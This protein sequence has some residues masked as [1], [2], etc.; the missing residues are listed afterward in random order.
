M[1]ECEQPSPSSVPIS[2]HSSPASRFPSPQA[3]PVDG[4]SSVD[5]SG[6]AVEDVLKFEDVAPVSEEDATRVPLESV[7]VATEVVSDV[8]PEPVG[9]KQ[10]AIH[11]NPKYASM[12]GRRLIV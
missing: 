6:C 12:T 2:S 9:E 1:Q 7:V 11:A 4:S 5:G 3:W 8:E 10:P